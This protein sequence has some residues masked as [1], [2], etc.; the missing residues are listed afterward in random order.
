MKN[1]LF[2][3][4]LPGV[5]PRCPRCIAD[6]SGQAG[7]VGGTRNDTWFGRNDNKGWHGQT[8]FG[9]VKSYTA[10]LSLGSGT[11]KEIIPLRANNSHGLD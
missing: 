2:N 11:L 4:F 7:Q 9:R 10:K 3:R 6:V 8:L 1:D 5:R